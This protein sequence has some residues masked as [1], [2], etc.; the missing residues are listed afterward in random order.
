MPKNLKMKIVA[1]FLGLVAVLTVLFT[2]F[3][4]TVKVNGTDSETFGITALI[5]ALVSMAVIV[6]AIVIL[7]RMMLSYQKNLILLNEG[8]S[9]ITDN[10]PGGM[11]CCKNN[12][13]FEVSFVSDSFVEMTGYTKEDIDIKFDGEFFKMLFPSDRKRVEALLRDNPDESILQYRM[14]KSDGA[15]IWIYDKGKLVGDNKKGSLYYRVLTDIT[16]LKT[17]EQALM[18]SKAELN[19][20]NERYRMVLDQSNYIVFD[21]DLVTNAVTYSANYEKKFG[22]SPSTKNFPASFVDDGMVH[23]DDIKRFLSFFEKV[24]DD[25]SAKEEEIRIRSKNGGYSWYNI[26]VST[27]KGENGTITRAIGRMADITRQ[28]S[29]TARIL[30]KNQIDEKTGLMNMQT[31]FDYIK[32]LTENDKV[33]PSALML[34]GMSKG[35]DEIIPEFASRL[36]DLFRSTDILGY[37]DEEKFIVFMKNCNKQLVER[38]SCEILSVIAEFSKE[39]EIYGNIGISLFPRDSEEISEIYKKAQLAL[40]HSE[41]KKRSGYTI[42]EEI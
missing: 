20:V 11:V 40:V 13:K 16:D 31:A 35:S 17:A 39:T 29:D 7:V 2:T 3:L 36:R 9:S 25:S 27:I 4:H 24:K 33:T 12:P 1:L 28:R 23:P 8:L 19:L 6:V 30:T 22:I 32:S 41:N 21:I 15:T 5:H 18:K 14:I 34:I 26:C 37:T 42:Y 38:R 10:I